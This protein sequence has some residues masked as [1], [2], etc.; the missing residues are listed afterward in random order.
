MTTKRA[1][2]TSWV[3]AT[4]NATQDFRTMHEWLL[5]TDTRS[6]D[7]VDPLILD[8]TR[9][10]LAATDVMEQI[11]KQ[12]STRVKSTDQRRMEK[13]NLALEPLQKEEVRPERPM[14]FAR[15]PQPLS[16]RLSFA[17]ESTHD[18]EN[19]LHE[20]HTLMS[21]LR[22]PKELESLSSNIVY[23]L[24]QVIERVLHT[25]SHTPDTL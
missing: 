8:R 3:E 13:S 2:A 7:G 10:S 9:L 16:A 21:T 25:N 4:E 5:D 12:S 11:T 14:A 19:A 18:S 22:V 15:L 6:D 23:Q 20:C 24:L 17:T 1:I